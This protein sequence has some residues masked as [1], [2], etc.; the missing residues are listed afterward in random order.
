MKIYK[1]YTNAFDMFV[2]VDEDNKVRYNTIAEFV[3]NVN[4]RDVEDDTSWDDD[5]MGVDFDEFMCVDEYGRYDCCDGPVPIDVT[6]LCIRE[7]VNTY[8]FGGDSRDAY[9]VIEYD[10]GEWAIQ[11][12]DQD[13]YACAYYDFDDFKSA[14]LELPDMRTGAFY[15]R[16]EA[17]YAACRK[18]IEL[19]AME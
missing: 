6:D 9:D 19:R 18:F 15:G 16:E 2:T 14:G 10:D 4:I 7:R 8:H 11:A 5:C 17:G 1:V 13:G 3:Y 12:S